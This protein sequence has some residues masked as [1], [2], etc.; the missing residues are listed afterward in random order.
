MKSQSLKNLS[1]FLVN[2]LGIFFWLYF[3]FHRRFAEIHIQI[4]GIH[5]PIFVG[6]IL[7]A[8]CFCFVVVK[9]LLQKPQFHRT[10]ILIVLYGLWL[11]VKVLQ[12]YFV[13]GPLALRNAALFYYPAFILI[14][15]QL[16]KDCQ[17]RQWYIYLLL[18]FIAATQIRFND[19]GGYVVLPLALL[20]VALSLKIANRW[21][22]IA[23]FVALLFLFSFKDIF[24][25]S[26]SHMIGIFVSLG[27]L[28]LAFCTLIIQSQRR[29]LLIATIVFIVAA[30]S[31][32]LYKFAFHRPKSP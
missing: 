8:I 9:W 26:R 13:D 16:Y 2:V 11:V 10:F 4:P 17:L 25:G 20:Y 28:S 23:F 32:G 6:E 19:L 5:L 14:G 18:F 29:P 12:G 22:K 21:T 1:F 15:Y 3:V 30:G 24:D 31:F 27:Y 7:L